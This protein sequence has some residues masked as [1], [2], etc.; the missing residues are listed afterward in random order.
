MRAG[1]LTMDF[2]NENR[3]LTDYAD[4]NGLL[5]LDFGKEGWLYDRRLHLRHYPA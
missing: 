1:L 4:G 5:T 3:C 2:G